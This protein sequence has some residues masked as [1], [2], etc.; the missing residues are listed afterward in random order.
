MERKEK[1]LSRHNRGLGWVRRLGLSLLL[2]VLMFSF[3]SVNSSITPFAAGAGGTDD[4]AMFHHD[5]SHSGYSTSTAPSTNQTLWSQTIGYIISSPAVVNR[6]VY[7]G[8]WLDHKVYCLNAATGAF[9]WSYTTGDRVESSPAVVGGRVYIGS[10]D[11]NVYC[12]NATTGALV[13][14]YKTDGY[15]WSS[16]AVADGKVY[17]GSLNCTVYCLNATNGAF[18]WSYGT[19]GSVESSPAVADDQVYVGSG[20]GKVYC[21]NALSG[22]LIW[23]YTT[24]NGVNSSPALA[25]GKVYVGSSNPDS[26]ENKVYC[27]NATTGTLVWSYKT[28]GYLHFSPAVAYGKVYVGSSYVGSDGYDCRVNCLDAANGTLIWNYTNVIIGE[29][30]PAVADGKVYIGSYD[31]KVYCLDAATGAFIWSY[32]TGDA[33]GSSPAIA[34]GKVYVGS[35]DN[36]MYCFGLPCVS[37]FDALFTFNNVRVIY[38]SEQTPKPLGCSQAMLSDWTA[39][40][41]IY[42]KLEN[43]TEGLDTDSAFVNQSSGKPVGA[44]GSGLISF[45]GPIVNPIV[46]YAESAAT[47]TGDRA[48]IKFYQNAETCYFQLQDG[49]SIQG[50]ALSSSSVNNGVDMFVIEAYRDRDGR[51]VML[52]Y[53]FG[54]KG[55]YAAGK[56]FDTAIY[57]NITA[58]PYN[59]IIVLWSDTNGNGFVN[60]AAGGDTYTIIATEQQ[61]QSMQLGND[62]DWSYRKSHVINSAVGA[63]TNYQVKVV[64]HYGLGSDSGGDVYLNSKCRSDFGDIRFTADDGVTLLNYWMESKTLY[65]KAVFWVKISAN[66]SS[67]NQTI[68]VYYGNRNATSTSNSTNMFLFFDDFSGDLSKWTQR[69]G[70]WSIDSSKYLKTPTTDEDQIVTASFTMRDGRI[71]Y[72]FKQ[73]SVVTWITGSGLSCIARSPNASNYYRVQYWDCESDTY[74]MWKYVNSVHIGLNGTAI[75]ADANWHTDEFLL[76]GSTLKG[77]LDNSYEL[78]A[79][80]TE[81]SANSYLGF[82]YGGLA[83]KYYLID[84][85]FVGKY[86]SPEPSHGAWGTEEPATLT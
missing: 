2:L 28:G 35:Y 45:G 8:S 18:V 48:P 7:V 13:W 82:R 71:R 68:Y 31:D 17:V 86:V 60:T 59:W 63:G 81:F 6:K 4:W 41:F 10:N 64:V 72:R 40:A 32:T 50:A 73:D 43:A 44:A 22:A 57:P 52:C 39:S 79:A 34:D 23:N 85:I 49:T 12:L 83:G 58:Y 67:S 16:P 5:L 29:S 24:G 36:K 30:S 25:D 1:S 14:S 74:E 42:T 9:V 3:L 47:P 15:V 80:D 62:N 51:N 70:N 61:H 11:Y 46:A 54:W 27:L 77:C 21:L 19:I 56:Y 65:G 78:E 20:D 26:A 69:S 53:G 76:Y 66:L 84:W 38:P 75:S 33:V 55:T 37:D